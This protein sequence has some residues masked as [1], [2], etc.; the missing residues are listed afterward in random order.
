LNC[1]KRYDHFLRTGSADDINN[2]DLKAD[3]RAKPLFML[4]QLERVSGYRVDASG[5]ELCSLPEHMKDWAKVDWELRLQEDPS[6]EVFSILR[7]LWATSIL[8]ALNFHF[9]PDGKIYR[10]SPQS[11]LPWRRGSKCP[12][13]YSP[14]KPGQTLQ[15]LEDELTDNL[16]RLKRAYL[17][18]KEQ[19]QHGEN[20]VEKE[21][22]NFLQM[23]H[24]SRG[25]ASLACLLRFCVLSTPTRFSTASRLIAEF[26]AKKTF[27]LV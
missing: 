3:S 14:T 11:L 25:N 16:E 22:Q 10:L 19:M 27:Q 23:I 15:D 2:G 20:G 1:R 13:R 8:F 5:M 17:I 12:I 7:R 24:T 26:Y 6:E 18:E 4:R 9:S 21:N